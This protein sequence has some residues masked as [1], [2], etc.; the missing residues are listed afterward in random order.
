VKRVLAC[1][2]LLVSTLIPAEEADP[3][4]WLEEVEGEKALA[5]AKEQNGRSLPKIEKV[6]EF[7]PILK[8]TLEILDSQDRIAYPALRG[9]H[10]YNFWQD[11][12]H[13]RGIWRRTSLVSYRTA[14]PRWETVI[15]LDALTEADGVP[16]VWKG[17]D[18]LPPEEVRCMVSLSRGGSDATEEREFDI[19]TKTF[20]EDG[21][22]L[23]EAKS[24]VSWLDENTLW[25]GTDFG[26]DSLTD[27]GYPRIV[28][29]WK[30]GTT[31]SEARTIYESSSEDV[32]AYGYSQFTPEGRYDV[33]LRVPAFFRQERFLLLGDRLVKLD[34]PEDVSFQGVFKDHLLASLRS[35]WT[36]DGTTYPQGALLGI[37]L[38]AFL[39]GG[40]D[41]EVLF[42]PTER[43][44]LEDVSTTRD[45]IILEVLDNV[46]GKLQTLAPGTGGWSRE[47]MDLPGL[48]SVGV[49][50]SSDWQDRFVYSYND[51]L[52]PVSLYLVENGKAEKVKTSPE[53]FSVE[54][55]SVAQHEATSRD[56]TKIP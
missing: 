24:S 45:R 39:Q 18:C 15:D 22:S 28:K 34:L 50:T 13:A 44:S 12:D 31:L 14:T 43:S 37:R 3:Y 4:L 20:V 38:N 29:L 17:A 55:M 9:D 2:A 30:R 33:V 41:F 53:F 47:D 49:T 27:S 52:T 10:V 23:P 26:P 11:K 19:L 51:F 35:D 54:G 48:G 32:G 56:G 36:V 25:V 40:R 21:F 42:K 7:K 8:R 46:R 6:K 5:W 1:L 16:W